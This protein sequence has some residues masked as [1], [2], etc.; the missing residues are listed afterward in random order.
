VQQQL[1]L[2]ARQF[3]LA[4]AAELEQVPCVARV[5]LDNL[6]LSLFS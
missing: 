6:T 1:L 3:L 2:P 5:A 4:K